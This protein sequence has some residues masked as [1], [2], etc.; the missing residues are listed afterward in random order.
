[1]KEKYIPKVQEATVPE[2]GSWIYVEPNWLLALSIPEWGELMHLSSQGFRYVWMYDR[3]AQAY[4]LCFQL[5]DHVDR[6]IAFPHDHAGLLLQDERANEEFGI[7]LTAGEGWQGSHLFLGGIQLRPHP[8][9]K[10]DTIS[11]KIK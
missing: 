1:M 7:I 4:L 6:A 8:E 11:K 2:E 3:V 9:W 5:S 10:P